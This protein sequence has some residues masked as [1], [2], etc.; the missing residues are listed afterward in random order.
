MISLSMILFVSCAF[1][2]G[3]VFGALWNS[4]QSEDSQV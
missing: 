3:A 1:S 2:A 4:L